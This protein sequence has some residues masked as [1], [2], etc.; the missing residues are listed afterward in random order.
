[1]PKRSH[2]SPADDFLEGTL[3]LN[4]YL[5]KHPSATF[6]MRVAGDSMIN[7]GIFPEDLLIVDRRLT[8]KSGKIVIAIL[9]GELT[10]KRLK[11]S[12]KKIWLV[13]ENEKYS[14]IEITAED[15]FE[16]WGIVT[17]VIHAV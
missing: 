10:V 9:N 17:T 4:E 7:T 6:F 5:I 2:P 3:D 16:I 8:A 13:P 11:K 12:H 1:M 15:Y 14:V